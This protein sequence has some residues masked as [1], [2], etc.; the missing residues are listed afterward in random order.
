MAWAIENQF[1]LK[2]IKFG[3]SMHNTLYY[4]KMLPLFLV[5]L[6][7]ADGVRPKIA[8]AQNPV[9][10]L[11]PA[12][13]AGER[14][15]LA[16]SSRNGN[17]FVS[18]G[19]ILYRLSSELQQL[20]NVP[21]SAFT[22]GLTTTADGDWLVACF[23]TSSCSVYNT[24]NLTDIDT[25]VIDPDIYAQGSSSIALFTAP[26]SGMQTFY[27][28]SG[29][30]SG[31]NRRFELLQRGFAGSSFSSD[32]TSDYSTEHSRQIY[33]GFHYSSNSYFLA[34]DTDASPRAEMFIIRVCNDG[35]F[36]ARYE[37][38]LRCGGDVSRDSV[39]TGVS[40]VAG[41]L[42]VSVAGR[43]CSYDLTDIDTIIDDYFT[44]CFNGQAFNRPQFGSILLCGNIRDDVSADNEDKIIIMCVS[45]IGT[46]KSRDVQL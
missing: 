22:V 5:L 7:A 37:L 36:N 8:A 27:V 3:V 35:G 41:T 40:E 19:G 21:I 2:A 6:F 33:G 24:S 44:I 11:S 28:G 39:I 29:E 43:V 42:V 1:Y 32:F 12:Q 26:L 45:Q 18:A 31:G 17:V 9:F 14:D 30:T 15:H 10:N 25:T 34:L 20:Q 16:S 23:N 4:S 38:E 46:R 13:I